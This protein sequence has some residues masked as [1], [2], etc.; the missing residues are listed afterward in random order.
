MMPALG[1]RVRRLEE[2]QAA[3]GEAPACSV[4]RDLPLYREQIDD[5]EPDG[6]GCAGCGRRSIIHIL[7]GG[8]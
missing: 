3:E 1:T 5:G 6:P 4:C 8:I 2:R 7:T